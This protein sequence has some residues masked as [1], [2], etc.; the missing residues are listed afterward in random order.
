MPDIPFPG[1][2]VYDPADP[3]EDHCG[4]MYYKRGP[5]GAHC[6]LPT[7][8]Q[9]MNS[10]DIVHGGLLL[11]FADYALAT[12]GGALDGKFALTVS[13]N[14]SFLNAGRVGPPLEA[15][16]ELVR[17]GKTLA[18]ARATV[19]QEGVKLLAASGVFRLIERGRAM[20][21]RAGLERAGVIA[22]QAPPPGFKRVE[23]NSPFLK[24]VG[25]SYHGVRDGT[26]IVVQP[27]AA[28]MRNS[29]GMLHGGMLM[30]FADNALSTE[31]ALASGGMVPITTSFAGEFLAA[32]RDGPLLETSVELMRTTRS[33]AFARGTVTQA[34]NALLNYSAVVM[35]KERG[36]IKDKS[37]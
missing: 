9:H 24:H 5:D 31:I 19:L 1:Y 13:L 34:G 29:G 35:L 37:A 18:F 33:V 36:K 16:A 8:P 11:S 10:G 21:Q 14:A 22:R 30:N 27:T 28:H 25:D 26:A 3:F 23:R 20:D 6:L 7:R 4:P 2:S 17:A 12:A 15:T 32:G